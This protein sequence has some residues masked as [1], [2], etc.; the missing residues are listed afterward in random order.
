MQLLRNWEYN[1]KHLDIYNMKLKQIIKESNELAQLNKLFDGDIRE[2]STGIDVNGDL[3]AKD[4]KDIKS[5]PVQ[6][7]SISGELVLTGVKL[8]DLKNFPRKVKTAYLDN[9]P[10]LTSLATDYPV[11]MTGGTVD[12][13][14]TGVTDLTGF[15]ITG[16]S[17]L[18]LS[19]CKSL[20]SL[21]GTTERIQLVDVKGCPNL[22]ADLTKYK[23]IDKIVTDVNSNLPIVKLLISGLAGTTPLIQLAKSPSTSPALWK[24][25][26]KYQGKGPENILNIMR[27]LRDAGF[28]E[29]ARI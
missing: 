4:G 6:L 26:Q 16:L 12:A 10:N 29:N 28:A 25:I 17:T 27:E 13:K 9:N 14:N 8:T 1:Q 15:Q 19:N 18:K 22:N 5:L 23:N 21:D 7:N 20:T 2:G 3:Y 11:D 24:I